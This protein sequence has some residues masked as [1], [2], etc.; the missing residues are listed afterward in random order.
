MHFVV[1]WDIKVPT[2]PHREEIATALK[3]CIKIYSWVRPLTTFYVV[4]VSS[5]QV[6]DSIRQCLQAVCL[7]YRGEVDLI[8]T[9][10]MQG[11][12][13]DGFLPGNLWTEI[14]QRTNVP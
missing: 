9:P 14:N 6:W 8:M 11:G 13:Y 5:Q 2:G 1:S 12:K 7:R 4:K 10:L 3:N